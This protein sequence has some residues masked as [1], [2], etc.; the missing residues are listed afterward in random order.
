MFFTCKTAVTLI[1]VQTAV[2]NVF[3]VNA[4]MDNIINNKFSTDSVVYARQTS[5]H[6]HSARYKGNR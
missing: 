3:S 5:S 4:V 2:A 6:G 1:T